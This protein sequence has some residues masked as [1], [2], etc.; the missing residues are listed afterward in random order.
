[1]ELCNLDMIVRRSLLEKGLPLH[2]YAEYLFHASAAIRE[3]NFDT[4]QIVNTRN[5]PV[6]SYGAVDVPS[7]FVNDIA[8]CVPV[9]G[10]LT[11]LPKQNWITPLRIHDSTG[12]FVANTVTANVENTLTYGVADT[13]SFF[14]NVNDYGEPTGGF[15]GA[16]GGTNQ[17]YKFIKG[18]RQ[19]QL[20]DNFKN[21][22]VVLMYLSNGQSLDNATQI[23]WAAFS[24]IQAYIDWKSSKVAAI[25]NS[26]EA[27]TFY[28][29]RRL[30]RARLSELTIADIKQ[31]LHRAYTAAIKN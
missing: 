14:W 9:G 31:T 21:S 19:I 15:F 4:L 13:W 12:D 5:L 16:N 10:T 24:T 2:W 30:L 23:D 17:G 28:N 25:K 18:R 3:L 29:E 6:N 22:N 8:V 26:Q 1:M 7:D 20:T 27:A 11:K